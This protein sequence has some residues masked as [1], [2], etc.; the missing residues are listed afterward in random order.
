MINIIYK[1]LFK[2]KMFNC[3]KKNEIKIYKILFNN[4]N[5][6]RTIVILSTIT[7]YFLQAKF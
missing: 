4:N 6:N 2:R 1:L 7:I 5:N 3:E